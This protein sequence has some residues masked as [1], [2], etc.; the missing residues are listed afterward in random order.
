MRLSSV[1]RGGKSGIG[2][3]AAP[4]FSALAP[5]ANN[6][7][8]RHDPALREQWQR[9]GDLPFDESPVYH[10]QRACCAAPGGSWDSIR[11][12]PGFDVI[13]APTSSVSTSALARRASG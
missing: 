5:D 9:N 11:W 6:I 12:K 1:T 8:E 3:L 4:G 2:E 7:G 13:A 10:R